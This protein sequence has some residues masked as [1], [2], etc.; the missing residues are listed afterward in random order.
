LRFLLQNV[1]A[2]FAAMINLNSKLPNVNTTI[3]TVMSKL[4]ADHHAINLSQGFPD[5]EGPEE[6]IQLTHQYMLSGKNQY[7]PMAGVPVLNERIAEKFDDLYKAKYHPEQEITITAGGTQGIF[8]ALAAVIQA[9]DE[10][11]IFEP[12]YDSYAPTIKLLGGL[13]KPFQ[14]TPPD[15]SIDWDMVKKLI[16]NRTRMII[17]NSPRNPTGTVLK[18]TDI[19]HLIKLTRNTDIL[20]LSDEVY[21]HIVFDDNQHLSMAAFPEL[22]DRSFIIASFG[23]LFHNTG[24]K[25]GYCVAP[26]YLMKE[27]R[28]VHQYL[29]FSVNAPVQYA[30]ADMLTQKEYYLRLSNF[31]AEKRF[32]FRNLLQQTRFELLPCE[33]SYFQCVNIRNIS[34]EKD[35]DFAKR[36]TVEHGVA[37]IPTSAFYT[38][39]L[40][41]GV[42]RFCFAKKQATLEQAVERLAKV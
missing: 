40:D 6:L 16:S 15:Y 33:G 38:K 2:I 8:T 13:V 7:A 31:F 14:L 19:D 10:V 27:F 36:L 9:G 25:V 21:E 17:L 23:K 42:I 26:E 12:A 32:F 29:V 24:W 4:A 1:I 35:V 3:F 34:D 30:L 39:S 37:S 18:Q 22:K 28:K 20:I 41:F 5:F 11:I